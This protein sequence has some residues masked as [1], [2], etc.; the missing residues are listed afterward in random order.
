M[1][2]LYALLCAGSLATG[3]PKSDRPHEV[4]APKSGDC[5]AGRF[6]RVKACVLC[7]AGKHA[8]MGWNVC[9]KCHK[10][11]T[12]PVGATA[13]F[14]KSKEPP[15]I[16]AERVRGQLPQAH[17]FTHASFA[18]KATKAPTAPQVVK[19]GGCAAGLFLSK[20]TWH[21][22]TGCY[23]CPSS[24]YGQ[25]KEGSGQCIDCPAGR[26]QTRY[27]KV[28]CYKVVPTPAPTPA[29]TPFP[30]SC[31]LGRFLTG[32][33]HCVLCPSGKFG[34]VI[35]HEG[36]GDPS[37]KSGHNLN[38]CEMCPSGRF[39]HKYG[40]MMC[41]WCPAGRHAYVPGSTKCKA[42]APDKSNV[43]SEAA[44]SKA[45]QKQ[46][47]VTKQRAGTKCPPGKYTTWAAGATYCI[48]CPP[49]KFQRLTGY[50]LCNDCPEGR[51]VPLHG[52]TKCPACPK[53]TWSNRDHTGCRKGGQL[54]EKGYI[55]D[56]ACTV[57]GLHVGGGGGKGKQRSSFEKCPAGQFHFHIVS[58]DKNKDKHGKGVCKR[59]PVGKYQSKT[60]QMHCNDCYRD[61]FQDHNGA[62]K[63]KVCPKGMY[64]NRPRTGC[65]KTPPPGSRPKPKGAAPKKAPAMSHLEKG[66]K[67]KTGPVCPKG[68]Y[69]FALDHKHY[70]MSCRKGQYQNQPGQWACKKCALGRYT[71]A[72]A[73]SKCIPC[74]PTTGGMCATADTKCD[75]DPKKQA[76]KWI[77]CVVDSDG[78]HVHELNLKPLTLQ[79]GKA[80]GAD[81]EDHRC[82]NI[83]DKVCQCCECVVDAQPANIVSLGEGYYWLKAPFL[84]RGGQNYK[85][86]SLAECQ[87]ACSD[88][89]LCKTG[90]FVTSFSGKGECWLSS[91]VNTV[92]EQCVEQCESFAKREGKS[93][94][95]KEHFSFD[96]PVAAARRRRGLLNLFDFNKK[97][98]GSVHPREDEPPVDDSDSGITRR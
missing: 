13:C 72:D 22:P 30:R 78:T 91:S 27:G 1:L 26:G 50:L 52:Q 83:G 86:G 16:A 15:A 14:S 97:A 48:E 19:K 53:T 65:T 51:Y 64:P 58:S 95:F 75:C 8:H 73:S 76:A 9:H 36:P 24:K 84:D 54:C 21:H 17:R 94:P 40:Q 35:S 74:G 2:V 90:T 23:K 46:V 96:E 18:L 68:R 12:S 39:Q 81:K 25:L 70:C 6:L 92:G 62:A 5:P 20:K 47:G 98:I 59:C 77:S 37:S 11:K 67:G 3:V 43:N 7:P 85:V 89:K 41:T 33:K 29:P 71:A 80:D 45:S 60:D 10:H 79:M 88:D 82:A 61:Q 57:A 44:L 28:L 4:I 34:V 42:G 55:G 38:G 93:D 31:P 49:G 56:K 32:P 87:K 63:C 69:T 66:V